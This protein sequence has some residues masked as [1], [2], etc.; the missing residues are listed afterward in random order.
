MAQS[1]KVGLTYG[2][3]RKECLDAVRQWPGC[4][5]VAGIQIIRKSASGGF[6]VNLRSTMSGPDARS[7]RYRHNGQSCGS[8]GRWRAPGNRSGGDAKAGRDRENDRQY[9]DDSGKPQG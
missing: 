1:E 4:E 3:L 7:P 2:A 8:Q 6:S 9:S 5:S